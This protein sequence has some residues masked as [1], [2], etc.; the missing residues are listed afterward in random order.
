METPAQER[1]SRV[2][3]LGTI[4][5]KCLR[6]I[7]WYTSLT[8]KGTKQVMTSLKGLVV[9]SKSTLSYINRTSDER[10]PKQATR[11]NNA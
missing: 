9:Y 1:K 3:I 6:C 2:L 11:T 5:L 10:F 8:P 4:M 7:P